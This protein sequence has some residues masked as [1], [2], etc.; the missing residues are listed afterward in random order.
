MT[1]FPLD[2]R[3]IAKLSEACDAL[4]E[5]RPRQP[6]W[7]QR[8]ATAY[9]ALARACDLAAANA[10]AI[11]RLSIEQGDQDGGATP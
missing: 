6:N 8:H 7:K 5:E 3:R 4:D 1:P 11:R 10:T 2:D 9:D